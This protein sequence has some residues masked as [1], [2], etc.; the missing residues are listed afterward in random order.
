MLPLWILR[1]RAECAGE[2]EGLGFGA[3]EQR[4]EVHRLGSVLGC[5]RVSVLVSAAD[6]RAII[7]IEALGAQLRSLAKLGRHRRRSRA[8]FVKVLEHFPRFYQ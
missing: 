8:T 4:D 6:R 2:L 3:P 1:P 7:S 5:R